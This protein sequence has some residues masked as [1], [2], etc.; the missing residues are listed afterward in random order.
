MEL[1]DNLEA[2]AQ[3]I[4][5][6]GTGIVDLLRQVG[7]ILEQ[8]GG[9]LTSHKMHA[10]KA[11]ILDEAI[12]TAME[13]YG[14]E[15]DWRTI[16]TLTSAL[17]FGGHFTG[18]YDPRAKVIDHIES[19]GEATVDL[20]NGA[21]NITLTEGGVLKYGVNMPILSTGIYVGGDSESA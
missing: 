21:G 9:T 13:Q 20:D 7:G 2:D 19:H 10:G 8:E 11:L 1:L 17:I 16:D 14:G 3:L 15:V 18:A 12:Y 4:I 6:K 5:E